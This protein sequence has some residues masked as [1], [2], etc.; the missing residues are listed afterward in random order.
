MQVILD[1]PFA[2]PGSAPIEDGKKGE[3]RDWTRDYGY[4]QLVSARRL[5]GYL[6]SHIRG[7]PVEQ[8]F[9]SI[10]DFGSVLPAYCQKVFYILEFGSL[11]SLLFRLLTFSFP[12]LL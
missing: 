3:F 6:S 9:L 7:A 10:R 2:R 4:S 5:V 11:V 12:D 1:S 8:L